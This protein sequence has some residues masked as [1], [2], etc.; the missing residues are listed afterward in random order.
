MF[1]LDFVLTLY[2]D[3]SLRRDQLFL[4]RTA[5]TV[6]TRPRVGRMTAQTMPADF[7]FEL[8]RLTE[9]FIKKPKP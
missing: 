7:L 2:T 6:G 8:V 4:L 3:I 1:I 5:R 9:K